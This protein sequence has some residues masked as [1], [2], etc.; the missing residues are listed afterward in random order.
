MQSA[1]ITPNIDRTPASEPAKAEDLESDRGEID[2][3]VEKSI[4]YHARRQAHYDLTHNLLMFAVICFG[5][6]AFGNMFSQPEALGLAAALVAAFDL[7]WS[8]STKARDHNFLRMRF[9]A[10]ASD[11]RSLD[12]TADRLADWKKK[13][14]DIENDEGPIYWAVEKSCFNEV[15]EALGRTKEPPTKLTRA[16]YWLMNWLRFERVS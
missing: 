3:S 10:L 16:E 14:L 11:I 15:R 8:L 7:V 12:P 5:S 2:F 13:R 1:A 6:A 9:S 4:R